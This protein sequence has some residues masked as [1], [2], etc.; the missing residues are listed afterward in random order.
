MTKPL[1]E[2]R[3]KWQQEFRKNNP[4]YR[5]LEYAKRRCKDVHH[6]SYPWYGGKGIKVELTRQETYKLWIRDNGPLL[7]KASLDRKD[8]QLNYTLDNCRFIEY[9]H[10]LDLRN[11]KPL[12]EDWRD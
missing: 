8:P 4:W 1:S 5:C 10:N 11:G 12:T 6:K 2:K 7:E 9:A 3:K